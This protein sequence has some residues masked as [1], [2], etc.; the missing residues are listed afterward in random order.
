M[1]IVH[2]SKQIELEVV[3]NQHPLLFIIVKM[4]WTATIG[5]TLVFDL[6]R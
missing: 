3:E 1:R 4:R 6:L 5:F 2:Q